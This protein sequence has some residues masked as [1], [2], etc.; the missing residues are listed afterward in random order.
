MYIFFEKNSWNKCVQ[1]KSITMIVFLQH[2]RKLRYKLIGIAEPILSVTVW[3]YHKMQYEF[4]QNLCRKSDT[5][6]D[7]FIQINNLNPN[8]PLLY[9]FCVLAT[10]LAIS[11]KKSSEFTMSV[12]QQYTCQ[13]GTF[14]GPI[15]CANFANGCNE[16]WSTATP[17]D[18]E[19]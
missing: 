8:L 18:W 4:I 12:W 15:I 2:S 13:A 7:E 19:V 17:T 3:Q 11:W 6:L 1:K 5:D 16:Q 9:K 14:V 10:T